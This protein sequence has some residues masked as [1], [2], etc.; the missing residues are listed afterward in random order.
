M[1]FVKKNI[2]L[3]LA[4][5]GFIFD[6]KRV[7]KMENKKYRDCSGK[8]CEMKSIHDWFKTNDILF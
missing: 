8:F 2:L 4:D 5:D 6:D 1:F 7:S 3:H